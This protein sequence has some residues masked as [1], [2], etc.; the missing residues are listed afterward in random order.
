MSLED[1]IAENTEALLKLVAALKSTGGAAAEE[2]EDEEEE[3]PE[4]K[5]AAKR[6]AA[7]KTTAKKTA[8]AGRGAAKKAPTAAQVRDKLRELSDACG[9]EAA[10]AL[11]NEE[12]EVAKVTDLDEEDYAEFIEACDEAMQDCEDAD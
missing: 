8:P 4:E 3:E 12:F 6:G 1:R 9:R 10:K 5:P 7:K 11:L 2:P